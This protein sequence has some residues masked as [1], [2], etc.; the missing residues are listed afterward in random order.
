MSITS[1]ISKKTFFAAAALGLAAAVPSHAY[2]FEDDITRWNNLNDS[3]WFY[4]A[5]TGVSFP[6][7][8]KAENNT[9][10]TLSWSAYLGMG[11]Q[12]WIT[13]V[14]EGSGV[15]DAYLGASGGLY[16][17]H[18]FGFTDNNNSS[19]DGPIYQYTT[20]E[21]IR[22]S[23]INV[24][25]YT[26]AQMDY[27]NSGWVSGEVVVAEG[28]LKLTGFVNAWYDFGSVIN[29]EEIG[30]TTGKVVGASR[31][32]VRNGAV[33][34]VSEN[35]SFISEKMA[36]PT[37]MVMKNSYTTFQ[38]LNNLIAG[39]LGSDVGTELRIG[40]STAYHVNLNVGTWADN[41][42]TN[43]GSIA[44]GNT[45]SSYFDTEL[46]FGGS[47]G[48][49]SGN[50]NI[51]KTG[52][53]DL[54]LL[55]SSSE[56]RG[57]LYAA[58]GSIVLAG[59]D[60]NGTTKAFTDAFGNS[61]RVRVSSSVGNAAS[62]NL[63]GTMNTGKESNGG[64][65]QGS[66][67]GAQEYYQILKKTLD[68]DAKTE[69]VIVSVKESFFTTPDAGTLVVAENQSIKNL[70]SY[71]NAG[72]SVSGSP[73][74]TDAVLAAA[75]NEGMLAP[76][77]SSSGA[78]G[79]ADAPIIAGTGVGSKI[80]IPGGNYTVDGGNFV[81]NT[82]ENGY[83][84]GGVLVVNQQ[85]G[86]GGIYQGSV[87][88]ARV[89]VYNKSEFVKNTDADQTESDLDNAERLADVLVTKETM[90]T[91]LGLSDDE[92]NSL[93]IAADGSFALDNAL[94]WKVVNYYKQT[95]L[96]DTYY[97]DYAA[98]DS[99]RGGLLVLEGAGDLALLLETANYSGIYIDQNRTGKTVLNISALNSL[100]G[101]SVSLGGRGI[102]SVVSTQS[103]TLG[104]KLSGFIEGS[105]LVFAT[106]DTIQTV[107]GTVTVGDS[108]QA[109]IGFSQIQDD[110]YGHVYVESGIG[111]NLSGDASVFANAGSVTLW[112]GSVTKTENAA[113]TL[114]LLSKNNV[115][116]NQVVNNLTGDSTAIINLGTGLLTT[117]VSSGA[118]D[119]YSG[120]TRGSY[121][122]TISGAGSLVK[123]GEGQFVLSGGENNRN[124]TGTTE[125]ADGS[126][127][128]TVANSLTGTS[129]L[130]L[131]EG[132]KAEMSGNQKIRT[133]YG[134]SGTSVSVE[135]T[136]TLGANVL[137]DAGENRELVTNNLGV[138]TTARSLSPDAS[139]AR[140]KNC[141]DLEGNLISTSSNFPT[142]KAA[143]TAY[144]T[145]TAKLAYSGF[146]VSALEAFVD[147]GSA[148]GS[149]LLSAS[150]YEVLKSFAENGGTYQGSAITGLTQKNL[151][152]KL[153]DL[154][155]D[156]STTKAC[157]ELFKS[158]GTVD[159]FAW[160][161][162]EALK[163]LF[164]S[165]KDYNAYINGTLKAEVE[166]EYGNSISENPTA[167]EKNKINAALF[168]VLC[169]KYEELSETAL[170]AKL[171]ADPV[172]M[173]EKF[174][175]AKNLAGT[176]LLSAS[177]MTTLDKILE[178]AFEEGLEELFKKY[179]EWNGRYEAVQNKKLFAGIA[180]PGAFAA[181]VDIDGNLTDT[182]WIDNP[183][184]AGTLTAGALVKTG[185]SS[186]NLTGTLAAEKI[187]VE[188][189]ELAI[190][191]TSLAAPVSGGISVS[192]NAVLTVNVENNDS[193]FNQVVSGDGNFVK[194]GSGK[195]TL[196][197][198]VLYTGTTTIKGG[199]LEMILRERKT[200]LVDGV[201]KTVL[202]QGDIIFGG[203]NAALILNQE[204]DVVW[205]GDITSLKKYTS[206]TKK[207]EGALTISG[208]VSLRGTDSS[209]V[210]EAGTLTLES[211]HF[212]H[213]AV[214]IEEKAALAL[215]KTSSNSIV[216][217]GAGA[218]RIFGET[219]FSGSNTQAEGEVFT[220]VVTVLKGGKLTLR[221][222]SVFADAELLSVNNGATL[223]LA[224]NA[225]QTL[226][227]IA[228]AGTLELGDGATLTIEGEG[229]RIEM[230]TEAGVYTFNEDVWLAAPDFS[231]NVSGRGTL[232]VVS[233]GAVGFSGAISSPVSVSGVGQLVLNAEKFGAGASVSVSGENSE[234][235]FLVASGSTA[236]LETGEI[237]FDGN[238]GKFGKLGNGTL[239]VVAS[240]F[241]SDSGS[242][243]TI[244][245]YDG[246][247]SVSGW[248]DAKKVIA[249]GAVL[250]MTMGNDDEQ[251]D[252]STVYGSG[253]FELTATGDVTL[254][255]DN[256]HVSATNNEFFN[257]EIRFV[258]SGTPYNVTLSSGTESQMVS[259]STDGNVK[260]IVS[261]VTF[262]Q[263]QNSEIAGA[264][265]VTG[266]VTVQGVGESS[267][268]VL[269][270][271]FRSLKVSGDDFS[272]GDGVEFKMKNIGF[273][274]KSSEPDM[275]VVIDKESVANTF[276]ISLEEDGER[277]VRT[278]STISVDSPPNNPDASS[279]LK[280]L[281]LIKTGVGLFTLSASSISDLGLG[282]SD[283]DGIFGVS[284]DIYE[285]L[286]DNGGVLN[287]GVAQ[288]KML[289]TW[290]SGTETLE[291][292]PGGNVDL[293]SLRDA[294]S[295]S[296]GTLRVRAADS[297]ISSFALDEEK[298]VFAETVSGGGNV[299]FEGAGLGLIVSAAQKYMGQTEIS[300]DVEFYGEGRSNASSQLT[301]V[302]NAKLSGGVSMTGRNIAYTV[303]AVR[304][305]DDTGA[306][307]TATLTITLSDARLASDIRAQVKVLA[308]GL[309]DVDSWE[310]LGTLPAGI[311]IER[312]SLTLK[313][314]VLSFVAKD[315]AFGGE[316]YSVAV[317]TGT[318]PGLPG[319]GTS[320]TGTA[321][322]AGN[323]VLKENAA[324]ELDAVAGD[325]ISV[326]AGTVVIDSGSLIYVENL[327]A[328]TLGKTLTLVSA[329]TVT[330]GSAGTGVAA[331]VNALKNANDT[332][333][334]DEKMKLAVYTDANG[335]I[336]A[337]PIVDDFAA[338]GA[339][340]NAG[341]SDSFLDALSGIAS[342]NG[343]PIID[344]E[345]TSTLTGAAKDLFFAVNSLSAS[346]LAEEVAKLSPISFAAMLSMP[347]SA[348]NSDVA[349]LHQ[350]LDQ[351][352][353]DGADPLR[354]GVEYEFFALAQSDFAENGT[355]SD[356]PNFDYNLYGVTAGFDWKPNFETT[357][358]FALGYTY[359]KAKI[360]DG[361]GKINMDDMRMTA[362]A[363]RLFGNCYVDAGIQAGMATFDTRRQTFVGATT[364]DTDSLFAGTFVTVGSVY[365]LRQNKKEGSGLYFTPSIGLSY[366]HTE[367]DGFTESG[368][369]GLKMEDADGDSLRARISAALQWAFPL[370]SWQVR[371]GFEVAYSHD[372]LGE[373]LDTDGRFAVGGS[374]FSTSGKA[375]PT[376]I[377][378]F[379]PT[380]DIM[381]SEKTSLYFGYGIDA[382]TDSGI[383]Q[384]VNAGFRHR[385]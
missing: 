77:K 227:A 297:G 148:D 168:K 39:D 231:G 238:N 121:A 177:E 351:R 43:T 66:A 178:N 260:L 171:E 186:V 18:R 45:S 35:E 164:S 307:G 364:G 314:G 53:G 82:D 131:N 214:K 256:V 377:F 189:G 150:E 142:Q 112:K 157:Q 345:N 22:D 350:R 365:A 222:S 362:F 262:I 24:T 241:A 58:G 305:A 132:T 361:G 320:V 109:E 266:S 107:G 19:D 103:S 321:N 223:A 115:F 335:E 373:E 284:K 324:V 54:T 46:A 283:Y 229:D 344:V 206:I 110:V 37:G 174:K 111:L 125:I 160:Y 220:G 203:D 205:T 304:N 162:P 185:D 230:S 358:G 343:A 5:E 274:F 140:F 154:Y 381:V 272:C 282:S 88:G 59:T 356:A 146:D 55:G 21:G 384:N 9:A 176:P 104:V 367:I 127:A 27:L 49:I 183:A 311:S 81:L 2:L 215:G 56:F 353:Y 212:E 73:S 292:V 192:R 306:A 4:T 41:T 10:E 348:F 385:F 298:A 341:I 76:L 159:G 218:L 129:A 279:K 308:S 149:V 355:G 52:G 161:S 119:T 89:T 167:E 64:S 184:F 97:V 288:G 213:A 74:A 340:Y 95:T 278:G 289:V 232:N 47:I 29:K 334:P 265:E 352:R 28:T 57:N 138:S 244:S 141:Y 315:S 38:F 143:T 310:T 261:D 225:E 317:N 133:L 122:G 287:L 328:E 118:Q 91:D 33:L 188:A 60:S 6:N 376:D 15:L 295:A 264:L 313:D 102:V 173:F 135:G 181:Q 329:G 277:L 25:Y 327:G 36:D 51:Y 301:V 228:G 151:L 194:T 337:K 323:V 31:I 291:T 83:M 87:V 72:Y 357:L 34:D 79:T 330:D 252:F 309:L 286:A 276:I 248:V 163:S 187:V 250:S 363:S 44:P 281:S 68:A 14:K 170:K 338:Y 139:F 251:P 200:T 369:A 316:E 190:E 236:D 69:E 147:V 86:M 16:N 30:Q 106:I 198:D 180:V 67:I 175:T 70:Q 368:T 50:G 243:D 382:D 152:E 20:K 370:D 201:S 153:A 144:L 196:G 145:A 318:L 259:V 71:F 128:L 202:P 246:T 249:S 263:A 294:V 61:V 360:H 63:A 383:S 378:S 237:S 62:V 92:I 235:I 303:N 13:F 120:L 253:V 354:E 322:I 268:R 191:S 224:D 302:S 26:A 233:T 23:G 197:K 290:T 254:S 332:L 271:D 130:I 207:G 123:G 124:F 17:Q 80:V 366:L 216:F 280:E 221:G 94:A 234:I 32:T 11:T 226:K 247:L 240:D 114:N 93:N 134:S 136:L 96:T 372:F 255:P 40:S 347:V 257:G 209:L 293:V 219:S 155:D 12:G 242:C 342:W 90:K 312:E 211:A 65:M 267:G 8:Y 137:P 172:G 156:L 108:R 374:K 158:K 179:D 182:S 245:V 199:T 78:T 99:V 258:S 116:A 300:G 285:T 275:K 42:R 169:K 98:D 239:S 325:S 319:S 7:I 273:G 100:P 349:R 84:L 166:A 296:A 75:T 48:S 333:R 126:L 217:S 336:C 105:R 269:S 193:V 210:A 339:D 331:V 3:D 299:N 346:S 326:G 270:S 204:D 195:L 208:M 165:V 379:G 1:R 359:G 113:S 117:V 380:V 371:L 85:A 375:L 101:S